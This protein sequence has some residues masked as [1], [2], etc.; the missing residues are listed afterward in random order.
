MT[1]RLKR[2]SADMSLLAVAIVWGSTFLIVQ[3]ATKETPVYT[4]LLWR[5][6][7]AAILMAFFS[8]KRFR[9]IDKETIFAGFILGAFLFLG[10]AFQT[11]A[12]VYTYSSTVGFI[13]GLNVVI[14]PFALLIIFKKNVSLYSCIGALTAA[15]GL[16]FLSANAQIS[17]GKGEF[18]ALICAVMFSLQIVFTGF[19]TKKYD[20]YLLVLVQFFAVSIFCFFGI[21]ALEN[22]IFPPKFD[23]LFIKAVI[24]TSVFATV[25]A[26]FVQTAM[27]KLTSSAKTA[28]IFTFEP[29]AAGIVGYFF[30]NEIFTNLQLFGAIL[31][32]MGMFTAEVGEYIIKK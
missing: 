30:A 6:L 19:Y 17:M 26:F 11:F 12:L 10:Y 8:I 1:S 2:F 29:I 7:L 25:F 16:Y 20:T 3:D 5:F 28:I 21:F 31:I 15:L 32:I 27:Q 22:P 4:F 14:I 13:T 18:Y 23:Y 24:I 9:M